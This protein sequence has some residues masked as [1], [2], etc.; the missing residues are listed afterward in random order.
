MTNTTDQDPG[1]DQ[2]TEEPA[3]VE[4]QPEPQA[5]PEA[6]PEAEQP[7][8]EPAATEEP[9][10]PEPEPE[11]PKAGE[12]V[13]WEKAYKGLQKTNQRLHRRVEQLQEGNEAL[14]SA[15]KA[16]RDGQT[17][18]IKAT[19]PED[20]ARALIEGQE[21]SEREAREASAKSTMR[22]WAERQVLLF[23]Q[24][25]T[26][27]GVD[28]KDIDWAKDATSLD[29]WFERVSTSVND[30]VARKKGEYVQTVERAQKKATQDAK[31]IAAE[32]TRAQLRRVGADRIDTAQPGGPTTFLTRLQ[33]VDPNSPEF[34]QLLEAAKDGRLLH[35]K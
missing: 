13:N 15:V 35:I 32:Q 26:A 12:D 11:Q 19:L 10:E 4:P 17:A 24:T 21:R 3:E 27:I 31:D 25:L 30:A 2:P 28:P 34:D 7:E 14:T 8:A 16:I 1:T 29:E 20:Q 22:D 18:L 6:A 9:T 33:N 5:E 23:Q